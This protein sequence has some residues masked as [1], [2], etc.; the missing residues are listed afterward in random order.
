MWTVVP[1]NNEYTT[2]QDLCIFKNDCS[3][4]ITIK[5]Y[6]HSQKYEKSIIYH[7]PGIKNSLMIW[8]KVLIS[9]NYVF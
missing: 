6:D 1:E 5:S 9:N 3:Y 7:I 2:D 8:L 4:N